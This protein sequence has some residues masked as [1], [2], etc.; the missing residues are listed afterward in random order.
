MTKIKKSMKRLT[1]KMPFLH[2]TLEVKL[3]L[4]WNLHIEDFNKL[5]QESHIFNP[6]ILITFKIIFCC[7]SI[8]KHL[9][10]IKCSTISSVVKMVDFDGLYPNN[11]DKFL[12]ID[13]FTA[14]LE[15]K[16][17]WRNNFFLA[18]SAG[19]LEHNLYRC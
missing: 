5:V 8:L 12:M 15:F 10:F 18:Y 17:C 4:K 3:R 6:I 1:A 19:I 16:D 9:Q 7:C 2:N 11:S 14:L 13:V